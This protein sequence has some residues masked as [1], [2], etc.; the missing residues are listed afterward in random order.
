[1]NTYKAKFS[2]D[3]RRFEGW[4]MQAHTLLTV[5]GQINRVLKKIT[6]SEEIRSLGSGRTDSGV[7]GL[8]QICKITLPI[9]IA[10]ASLKRALNSQLPRDIRCLEIFECDEGFHPVRDALWKS[11]DYIVHTGDTL[12]PLLHS[13]V[14]PYNYELDYQL[15]RE[16][17]NCLVG[18]KDFKN[19]STKGTEV[20]STIRSLYSA[21]LIME[22][23]HRFDHIFLDESFIRFRFIGSGFL[24]QMVRLLVSAVLEC[25]RGRV[26]LADIEAHFTATTELKIAPTAKPDGLYLSHVEYEDAWSPSI[27]K[28]L[29]SR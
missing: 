3:G 27:D 22:A 2:Y 5:Q 9:E 28:R 13:R 26:S 17:L 15:M 7:H 8:A 11:Y 18:E 20:A 16:A 21:D 1:M 12:N 6:K 29:Q 25:G 24:K 4:Q 19:F 10:S 14:T 23:E